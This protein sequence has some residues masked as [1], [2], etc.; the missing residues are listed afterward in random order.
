MSFELKPHNKEANKIDNLT[1]KKRLSLSEKVDLFEKYINEEGTSIIS[2]TVYEGYPIGSML[3]QIRSELYKEG[4]NTEKYTPVIIEK[5]E[6][7]GLL[8]QRNESTIDQKIDRLEVFCKKY[9]QLWLYATKGIE[10]KASTDEI[11]YINSIENEREREELKEKLELAKKDYKYIR[12][13]KAK[14]KVTDKDV[15]RLKEAGVGGAFGHK[16]EITK[17]SKI[18]GISEN[19]LYELDMIYGSLDDYQKAFI[20]GDLKGKI[21][22]EEVQHYVRNF[23]L[24]NPDFNLRMTPKMRLITTIFRWPAE[25]YV[26]SKETGS[27]KIFDSSKVNMDEILKQLDPREE[28]VI[29]RRF[30]LIDGKSYTLREI[31]KEFNLHSESIRK[32]EEKALGKLRRPQT[33]KTINKVLINIDKDIKDEFI[34]TYYDKKGIFADIKPMELDENLRK[35]LL[36]I[37]DKGIRRNQ[38]KESK[39]RENEEKQARKIEEEKQKE[40]ERINKILNSAKNVGIDEIGFSARTFNALQRANINTLYDICIM[41]E[42]KVMS[43]KGLG[44]R[45]FDEISEKISDMGLDFIDDKKKFLEEK[46]VNNQL[47]N[48]IEDL[49]GAYSKLSKED[50]KCQEMKKRVEEMQKDNEGKEI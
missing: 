42:K 20:Q 40:Q 29:K 15:E 10:G 2:D 49:K 31:G 39:K 13:R 24:A 38:A 30:G 7:L 33:I 25:K 36:G 21:P 46:Y 4:I 28:E 14:G 9:S 23:D 5:L 35:K 17:L 41:S 19:R 48:V 50:V 3:M 27:C 44:K 16:T 37:V 26:P 34:N 47:L 6:K 18:C 32:I 8:E 1:G 22:K 45:S 12:A 43:I 11:D